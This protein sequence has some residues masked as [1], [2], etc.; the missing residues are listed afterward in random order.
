MVLGVRF[1]EVY[2]D[3]YGYG[4]KATRCTSDVLFLPQNTL[5]VTYVIIMIIVAVL[6]RSIR[7]NLTKYEVVK[8]TLFFDCLHVLWKS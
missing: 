4:K 3:V 6:S 1:F 5:V 7:H 8:D 2:K